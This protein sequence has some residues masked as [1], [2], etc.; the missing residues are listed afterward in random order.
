MCI[1]ANLNNISDNTIN[2]SPKEQLSFYEKEIKNNKILI[3]G[4]KKS[5]N[6]KSLECDN[7]KKQ[8]FNINSDYKKFTELKIELHKGINI[9]R[10]TLINYE[11]EIEQLKNINASKENEINVLKENIESQDKHVLSLIK[12]IDMLQNKISILTYKLNN[13]NSFK[14]D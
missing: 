9:M 12:E 5:I 6:E 1:Y 13:Q 2:C 7:Y 3:D 10:D 4:L 8:L 11:K 14:E